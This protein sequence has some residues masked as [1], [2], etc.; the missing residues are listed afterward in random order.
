MVGG[1]TESRSA[2][3]RI[4]PNCSR[5]VSLVCRTSIQC[6]NFTKYHILDS[7]IALGGSLPGLVLGDDTAVG[8]YISPHLLFG[9]VIGSEIIWTTEYATGSFPGI[10]V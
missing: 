10:H 7:K 9:M 6:G 1:L 5:G 2:Y 8:L 4:K 3:R